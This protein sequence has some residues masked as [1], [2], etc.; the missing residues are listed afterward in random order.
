MTVSFDVTVDGNY[1]V[2][3][4][5]FNDAGDGPPATGNANLTQD[6]PP[7]PPSCE[8]QRAESNKYYAGFGCPE[9][10]P[11]PTTGL[12]PGDLVRLGDDIYT[13]TKPGVEIPA[14]REDIRRSPNWRRV[15]YPN[16]SP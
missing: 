3:I 1:I 14:N 10:E 8:E 5:A 6:A 12:K 4:T 16:P 13:P 9:E 11:P 7:A 15:T 2:E